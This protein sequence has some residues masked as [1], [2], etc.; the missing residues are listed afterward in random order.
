[1]SFTRRNFL[2]TMGVASGG[3]SIAP[4][5]LKGQGGS[6]NERLN[7][8]LVGMGAEGE[9]LFNAMSILRGLQFRA[10]CDIWETRR[11]Y[12][13]GRCKRYMGLGQTAKMYENYEDLIANEKDLDG[14]IIATPDFWH[15]PQTIDFLKAGVHVYCE[16]MM[17]NTKE[18][19]R[20]MVK[21]AQETGK[22]LQIGHQRKSNPRYKFMHDVL[23]REINR[24]EERR[25]GKECRSRWSPY[26]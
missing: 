25:V 23:M 21:A 4:G 22:F 18:G 15:A 8:A 11:R 16:K 12:G 2:K 20:S 10:V 26:H 9:V 14:V 3:L 19:A 7:I 1:M 24:S 5:F 13:A 6:P 17:S